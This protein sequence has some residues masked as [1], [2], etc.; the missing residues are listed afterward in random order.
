MNQSKKSSTRSY[1]FL[2]P[3]FSI[4]LAVRADDKI[5]LVSLLSSQRKYKKCA[6]TTK[7]KNGRKKKKKTI[8][9]RDACSA[10]A[11]A[12]AFASAS[13]SAASG[14][15]LARAASKGGPEDDRGLSASSRAFIFSSGLGRERERKRTGRATALEQKK[16]FCVFFF[17]FSSHSIRLGK[18]DDG[19]GGEKNKKTL[20]KKCLDQKVRSPRR[21]S[22]RARNCTASTSLVEVRESRGEKNDAMDVFFI[23]S[24]L[25]E[26]PFV[27]L[28]FFGGF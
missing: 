19:G 15:I 22:S 11:A 6:S 26:L 1:L 21:S 10:S 3:L 27:F 24:L 16:R 2:S 8:A 23:F 12:I 13:R 18:K 5:A 4:S 20:R 28:S 17:P 14:T 9:P 25:L 7:K